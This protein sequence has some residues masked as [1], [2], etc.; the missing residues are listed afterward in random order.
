MSISSSWVLD[1]S[2]GSHIC[3]NVQGLRRSRTLA[4]GEINIRVGNGSNVTALSIGTYDLVLPSGLV[5]SLEN[6]YYVPA[7]SRNII[8]ISCLDKFG[9]SFIIKSN[10]CSIYFDNLFYGI[11]H[12]NSGLYVLD[13]QFSVYNINTK[14]IKSVETN[15]TYL[16]HCRL[17]HINE[18]R[19]SKLHK[20]RILEPFD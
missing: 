19:I 10:C 6:C 8:S 12:A 17:G 14:R 13:L 1:T 11:A 7:L 15:Q 5:L 20:D 2:C 18:K 4:K 16:W 3:N 9:F